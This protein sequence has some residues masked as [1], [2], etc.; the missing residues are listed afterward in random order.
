MLSIALKQVV[1]QRTITVWR[2]ARSNVSLEMHNKPHD[3]K[4]VWRPEERR[5]YLFGKGQ[6]P[7]V[8]P[9]SAVCNMIP[10]DSGEF[11]TWYK[12]GLPPV[13]NQPHEDPAKALDKIREINKASCTRRTVEYAKPVEASAPVVDTRKPPWNED[14]IQ[15]EYWNPDTG[16][17]RGQLLPNEEVIDKPKRK[18]G[19]PKKKD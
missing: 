17:T 15:A 4:M 3:F 2:H 9:E 5:I 8:I 12:H 13:E 19:R 14:I 16:E 11:E 1:F 7:L 10:Y 18:R 6:Q